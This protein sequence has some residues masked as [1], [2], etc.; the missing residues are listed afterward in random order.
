[1]KNKLFVAG[2]SISD[3]TWVQETYGEILAKQIEFDYVHEGAGGG[4][5]Y[6]IWRK[7]SNHIIDGYLKDNDILIVQYTE[8]VR[9]EFWSAFPDTRVYDQ[10]PNQ[11]KNADESHD[12]GTVIRYKYG[13]WHWQN[14]NEEK[15]FFTQ[16]EKNFVNIKF[17]QENFRVNNYNFQQMLKNHNIKTVFLT[18]PRNG[19][20]VHSEEYI[21]DYFKP[22]E[23]V[24]NSMKDDKFNLKENDKG[25][26]SQLGHSNMAEELKV[27]LQKLKWI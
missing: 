16:Y 27:H 15:H 12:N 20:G 5:N 17:A 22:Y 8:A 4:S 10:F 18:T 11:P 23:F 26:F 7:I 13:A 2:C 14:F 6:R 3:Y 24:D 21:I 25:H 1:M 19:P 9:N